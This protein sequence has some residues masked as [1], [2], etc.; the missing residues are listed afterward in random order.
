M[1]MTKCSRKMRPVSWQLRPSGQ[2]VGS[3]PR[4]TSPAL[5]PW[6]DGSHPPLGALIQLW[7]EEWSTR[8]GGALPGDGTWCLADYDAVLTEAGD[9]T[10]KFFRLRELFKSIFGTQLSFYLRGGRPR[11][12]GEEER[13]G[14]PVGRC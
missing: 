2:V 3:A 12:M 4:L 5:Q 14:F 7:P 1:S 8:G 6:T 10:P 13:E 11:G 9:Y